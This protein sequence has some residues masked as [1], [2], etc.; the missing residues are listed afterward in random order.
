M[1]E[2]RYHSWS[3][4]NAAPVGGTAYCLRRARA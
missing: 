2:F 1:L 4:V 3:E